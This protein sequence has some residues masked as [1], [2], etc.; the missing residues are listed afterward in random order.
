M[1]SDGEDMSTPDLIRRIA[2]QM[3]RP[4]RL[5]PMPTAVL[6]AMG[7]ITGKGNEISRLCDSLVVD[8]SATRQAF[9]WFPPVSITESLDR[10]VQWYLRECKVK[11][12]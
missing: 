3:N 10:T 9:D 5:F 8:I 4:A 11:A 1:V 12:N 7:K 6:R 2:Q